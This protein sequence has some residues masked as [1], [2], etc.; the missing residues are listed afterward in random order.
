[1][2]LSKGRTPNARHTVRDRQ[3]RQ[4]ATIIERIISDASHTVPDHYT[5]QFAA[6]GERITLD[7]RHT[8]PDHYT[9]QFAVTGERITL[10][11]RHTVGD[12]QIGYK[13]PIQIKVICFTQRISSIIF[14]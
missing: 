6:T 1:M 14:K 10:D 3:A 8:V 9:R 2:R 11:T 13:S 7:T 4:S 5:R 12:N